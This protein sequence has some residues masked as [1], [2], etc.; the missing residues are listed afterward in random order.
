MVNTQFP[1][2][3]LSSSTINIIPWRI[4]SPS[5]QHM[6]FSFHTH[7]QPSGEQWFMLSEIHF[8][9]WFIIKPEHS[10][11][12][13]NFSA[14][15]HKFRQSAFQFYTAFP[16][17]LVSRIHNISVILTFNSFIHSCSLLFTLCNLPHTVV[18]TRYTESCY[19]YI[20]QG[21]SVETFTLSFLR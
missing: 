18:I 10:L 8:G 17:L 20:P 19:L 15:L 3:L 2:K 5:Y 6:D 4:I 7:S 12:F 9:P 14:P 16:F 13:T 11:S 1:L 21:W